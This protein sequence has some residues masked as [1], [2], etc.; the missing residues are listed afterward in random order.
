MSGLCLVVTGTG[1][2]G[3]KFTSKVLE[4]A[5][6]SV[7]HQFIFRPGRGGPG[8]P[9]VLPEL[10]ELVTVEDI[11]YRLNAYKASDWGPE[12]ET[13]WLAAPYLKLPEM[14]GIVTVH[15]VRHPKKVIDSLVK[16]EVFENRHRYGL[17]TDF[18][19]YWVPEMKQEP[20]PIARAGRFYV[21]WNRIIEGWTNIFWNIEA[22]RLGL[23]DLLGVHYDGRD[24]F[25]Q[26]GY[27]GRGGPAIDCDLDD[28]GPKLRAEILQIAREYGYE[29]YDH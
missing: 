15:L 20:T 17:Y 4:S 19:H 6:L 27:N 23:L 9:E 10:T 5:G 22:D 21:N 26:I 14:A 13:S 24:I 11:Q 2:C 18:A 16:C 7:K 1:R 3:T 25:N 8:S 28:F 12:A 29:W